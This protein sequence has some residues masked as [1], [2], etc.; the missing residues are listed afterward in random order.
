MSVLNPSLKKIDR[1]SIRLSAGPP[2]FFSLRPFFIPQSR[3]RYAS[4]P[5]TAHD[6]GSEFWPL[7]FFTAGSR[8]MP[9]GFRSP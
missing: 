2:S 6:L 5:P 8:K 3:P 9:K 4:S 1:L 7:A